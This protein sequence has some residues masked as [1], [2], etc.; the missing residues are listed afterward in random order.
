MCERVGP[1]DRGL[2]L[3]GSK[4][5]VRWVSGEIALETEYAAALASTGCETFLLAVLIAIAQSFNVPARYGCIVHVI[6][7]AYVFLAAYAVNAKSIF[8]SK[9]LVIG[10]EST[11]HCT[12]I[13]VSCVRG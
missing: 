12:S 8:Q 3:V 6:A 10:G 7:V 5:T 11:W 4:V 13:G 1:S 9:P 2:F